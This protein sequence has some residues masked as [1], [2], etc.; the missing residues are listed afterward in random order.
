MITFQSKLTAFLQ[1]KSLPYKNIHSE[2]IEGKSLNNIF[3]TGT[4]I[5]SPIVGKNCF[6]GAYSYINKGGY[7]R[8]NVFI[9]RFCSIGRRVTI[10]AGS[11][12]YIGISTH[13]K[14]IIEDRN[15]RYT[16]IENDVWIGDGVVIMP[17]LRIGQGAVIGANAV[18]TKNIPAYG[19][20]VGQPAKVI[21]NRFSSP[22]I[23]K[24]VGCDLF[25]RSI[26][27]LKELNDILTFSD[28]FFEEKF[29]EWQCNS[30]QD[31]VSYDTFNSES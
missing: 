26:S 29:T 5:K 13:P 25:D 28:V 18:V 12:P 11:H 10:A 7:V 2:D 16:V 23:C 21:K 27:A 3:E 8:S 14:L 9:G 6:F 22:K 30:R 17:G 15:I 31:L 20:A 19:I 4:S 24:L 1:Q